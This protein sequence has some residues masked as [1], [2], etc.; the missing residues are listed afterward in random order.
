[1]PFS[2]PYDWTPGELVT[3]SIMDT[4]VRDQFSA[5]YPY[6]IAGDV[7]YAISSNTLARLPY[8]A[9]RFFSVELFPKDVALAVGDGRY[10]M[11]IPLYLVGFNL[12]GVGGAVVTPS[13]SGAPTVQIARGRQPNA[14]TAHSYVDVLS[15]RLTIDVNEYDS[16]YAAAGAVINAANDDLLEGDLLRFDVDVA[17]TGA[18]GLIV[19][20][21]CALP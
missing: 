20:G 6:T 18:Q 1:M 17:G 3:A 4:N 2:T 16:Q 14:T 13:T 10:S 15:T 21:A 8:G 12:V 5:L 7:A 11:R 19:T 9:Y